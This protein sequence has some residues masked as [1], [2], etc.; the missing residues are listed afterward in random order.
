MITL[1]PSFVGALAQQ[2]VVSE[3]AAIPFARLPRMERLR[4]QGKADE[5]EDMD[6]VNPEEETSRGQGDDKKA[7]EDMGKKKMRGKNKSLKRRVS[8]LW[9]STTPLAANFAFALS[10]FCFSN[11]ARTAI[12]GTST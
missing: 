6:A 11:F 4:V 9:L 7:S 2:P 5:T 3:E 1:D 12:Y 10:T 8:I